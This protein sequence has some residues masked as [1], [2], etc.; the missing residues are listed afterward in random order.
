ML[1]V[2]FFFFFLAFWLFESLSLYVCDSLSYKR[3][4]E[5]VEFVEITQIREYLYEYLLF[6]VDQYLG[7]I[8]TSDRKKKRK[9][10]R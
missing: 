4:R 2:G 5:R 9:K 7:I 6:F 10:K 3:D 1:P 8:G